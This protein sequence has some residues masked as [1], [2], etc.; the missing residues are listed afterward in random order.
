[1]FIADLISR[2][3]ADDTYN[4]E[5]ELTGYIH[6]I[7]QQDTLL[8]V[9]LVKRKTQLDQNLS[10]V[11]KYCIEGWPKAKSDLPSI[12]FLKHYYKLRDNLILSDELLYFQ[13]RL[14]PNK[15]KKKKNSTKNTTLWT[16]WSN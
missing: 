3:I 12:E 1:M 9:E 5:I 2:N 7:Y 14:V 6:N 4:N 13:N 15:L 10:Q 16:S 11:S 8:N